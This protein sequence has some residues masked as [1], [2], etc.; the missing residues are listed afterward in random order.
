MRTRVLQPERMDDPA[1]D[2]TLH[3]HALAGLSRLNKLSRSA[4]ILWSAIADLIVASPRPLR[5]LDIATGSGDLPVALAK[6]A[7]S[8]G[9]SLH[10]SACDTSEVALAAARERASA[11]GE[12]INFFRLDVLNHPLPPGYDI[13]TCSLFFHHLTD[14][15]AAKL[16]HAM[17][18]ATHRR[19]VI[20][21]L[22]RDRFNLVAV[23]L[24]SRLLTTC[25]VVHTDGPL[26]VRAAFTLAEVREM[27]QA[28]GLVGAVV[29][30]RFPS[31]FLLTWNKA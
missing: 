21:D 15:Q 2:P 20:N 13:I 25:S 1:L 24:A 26:S 19:L 4:A 7:H 30:P 16:L 27:A 3:R 6:R 31:R 10:L 29:A 12:E 8:A 28:A 18:D 9:V 17:R 22:L 11:A 14:S 23:T 5:L